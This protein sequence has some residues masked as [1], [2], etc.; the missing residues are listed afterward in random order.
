MNLKRKKPSILIFS[1]SIIVIFFLIFLLSNVST[2]LTDEDIKAI[3][4]LGFYYHDSRTMDFEDQL[5]LIASVQKKVIGI[6]SNENKG[7]PF[8]ECREPQNLLKYKKGICYDISRLIEKILQMNNFKV[9]HVFLFVSKHP[10]LMLYFRKANSHAVSEVLTK[11]GWLLVD[12]THLFLAIDNEKK[13]YSAGSLKQKLKSVKN[14]NLF[15]NLPEYYMENFKYIYGLYSKHG[16]FYPPFVR[17]PDINWY[18]LLYHN[19]NSII[20]KEHS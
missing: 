17:V 10:T 13:V 8:G 6:I 2:K 14:K 3:K 11:G 5:E 16:M 9:R 15:S 4:Q 20:K 18:Q 7:I 1:G 12:S 19:I